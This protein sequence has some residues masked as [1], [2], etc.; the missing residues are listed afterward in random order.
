MPDHWKSLANLLGAPGID[1]PESAAPE[2][3]IPATTPAT[4]RTKESAERDSHLRDVEPA[5]APSNVVTKRPSNAAFSE[6]VPRDRSKF[7]TP[8][9]PEPPPAAEAADLEMPSDKQG[10]DSMV[11]DSRGSSAKPE[12]EKRRS[13]WDKLTKL[14]GMGSSSD[15]EAAPA[16]EPSPSQPKQVSAPR[17][18]QEKVVSASSDAL[19]AM[20]VDVPRQSEGDWRSESSLRVVDDVSWEEEETDVAPKTKDA[21]IAD[22]E[23]IDEV[24]GRGRR[25]HRRRP[26]Q[27][28]RESDQVS[29]GKNARK[30][31]EEIAGSVGWSEDAVVDEPVESAD[32]WTEPETFA[33]ESSDD[34]P[35]NAERRSQRR[36]R[37]GS[38]HRQSD[39]S[40]DVP[41]REPESRL[42]E[43]PRREASNRR[44]DLPRREQVS[45][46]D[47]DEKRGGGERRPSRENRE[48]E[49]VRR[50]SPQVDYDARA[51][52]NIDEV[53]IDHDVDMVG[54]TGEAGNKHRKIPTW[55]DALESIIANNMSNHRRNE[56][57][58]DGGPRG[59]PRGRR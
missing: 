22:S 5:H 29:T 49:P 38:R 46:R 26:G 41:R 32:Q 9:K 19:E 45:K 4:D 31:E 23:S 57:Q 36:H 15:V 59:R 2:S 1:M 20:F 44:E 56:G 55:S 37:R 10:R 3:S 48:R 42:E 54:D 53:E 11:S 16:I 58:R 43:P 21:P 17:S 18:G 8:A 28:D 7:R 51:E 33:A 47:H 34:E 30:D 40:S 27:R 39:A 12:V 50:E 25:R 52:E 24:R 14:F 6:Q 13:S 35:P